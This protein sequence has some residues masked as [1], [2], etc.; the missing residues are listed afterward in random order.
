MGV[1]TL[2]LSFLFLFLFLFLGAAPCTDW[3]GDVIERDDKGFVL[4][5]PAAS[6]RTC[7]ASRVSRASGAPRSRR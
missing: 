3:L 1:Q 7:C 6:V 2:S 5:G 4:T